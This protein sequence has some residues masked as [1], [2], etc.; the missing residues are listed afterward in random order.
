M[1]SN[2]IFIHQN[3]KLSCDDSFCSNMAVI[4]GAFC[5]DLCSFGLSSSPTATI[6]SGLHDAQAGDGGVSEEVQCQEET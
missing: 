4:A 1:F 6:H 5:A 2:T 3:H